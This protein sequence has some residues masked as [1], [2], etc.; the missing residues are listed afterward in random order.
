MGKF[1]LFLFIALTLTLCPISNALGGKLCVIGSTQPADL[2]NLSSLSYSTNNPYYNSGYGGECTAFAWGRAQEKMGISLKF[3]T[4]DYPDAKYWWEYGPVS[5]LKLTVGQI[6]K[7]N[8]IAVWAGDESNTHGHVAYVERV[9]NEIVYF[10][11]ANIDTYKTGGGYDGCLK[12][13]SVSS[14]ENRG[15]GVGKIL[16][17]IYLGS[18]GIPDTGQANC[19][20][21]VGNVITCPSPGQRFYGQ[22]ANY[23]INPPSYT[24][25]DSKGNALSDSAP[26]WAMVRDNVTGLVWEVKTNKDGKVNYN[27]PHDADNTYTWYDPSD[28]YPGSQSQHDTK[29]FLDALNAARFGGYSDWRLPTIKELAYLVRWDIPYPGPTIDTRYFP[30]TDDYYWSSTTYP[31]YPNHA[32]IVKFNYGRDDIE[33]KTGGYCVRAVRGGQG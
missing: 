24:K 5:L 15:T 23:T 12:S 26:S 32:W 18:F 27:D 14:F 11:E 30:N 20:D 9:E 8:C 21:D 17:Y 22:D 2:P 25:L 16:G 19:Y 1:R 29:D 7:D 4:K 10:N 3:N 13:L 28:P 6:V 31:Y 33:Y